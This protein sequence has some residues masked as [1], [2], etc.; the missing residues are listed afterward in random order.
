MA[1]IL[2]CGSIRIEAQAWSWPTRAKLANLAMD[3]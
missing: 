2:M 3:A 1:G